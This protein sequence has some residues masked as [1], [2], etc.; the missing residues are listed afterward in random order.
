MWSWLYESGRCNNS[1]LACECLPG[2]VLGDCS[3]CNPREETNKCQ[4]HCDVVCLN[5]GHCD[6]LTNICICPQNYTGSDCSLCIPQFHEHKC[7]IYCDMECQNKA[8]CDTTSGSCICPPGFNGSDCSEKCEECRVPICDVTTEECE[9]TTNC[10]YQ[11][12]ECYQNWQG[13]VRK[14]KC[15]G[16]YVKSEQLS[17]LYY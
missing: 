15:A 3:W 8:T 5:T 12:W 2:Y 10:K 1:S 6:T 7:V 11:T 13:S 14:L 16:I 17:R 9:D 4:Q